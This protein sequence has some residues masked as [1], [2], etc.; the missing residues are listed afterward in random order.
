MMGM[1]K[2][3]AAMLGVSPD[4]LAGKV[5][6]FQDFVSKGSEALVSIAEKQDRILSEIETIK[7]AQ[8]GKPNGR[9]K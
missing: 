9:T 5:K 2:M 6:E 4:E 8:K 7:E 3:L 1:E